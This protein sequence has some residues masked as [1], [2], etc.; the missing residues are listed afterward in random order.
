MILINNIIIYYIQYQNWY[1]CMYIFIPISCIHILHYCSVLHNYVYGQKTKSNY[2]VFPEESATNW[3]DRIP[4]A[5]SNH[6]VNGPA[7]R[8]PASHTN[9]TL[10]YHPKPCQSPRCLS[11]RNLVKHPW[12]VFVY[13][14]QSQSYDITHGLNNDERG[15]RL[16]DPQ[17]L[18]NGYFDDCRVLTKRKVQTAKH[19]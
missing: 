17:T 9:R 15:T 3:E 7:S 14:K 18:I 19:L 11:Q 4:I 13:H 8:H 10:R 1:T 5:P 16:Q 6:R 2:A 12:D